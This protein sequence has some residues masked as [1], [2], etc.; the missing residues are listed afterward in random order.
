MQRGQKPPERSQVEAEL[1]ELG[2]EVG[3]H[4]SQRVMI[5]GLSFHSR[6]KYEVVNHKIVKRKPANES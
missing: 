1:K 6:P 2:F 3:Q 4:Y 5:I